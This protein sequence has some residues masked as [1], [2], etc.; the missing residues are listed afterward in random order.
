MKGL[1]WAT[2]TFPCPTDDGKLKRQKKTTNRTTESYT[3]IM[4]VT[5]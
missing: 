1:F 2:S 4:E 3:P 5:Q